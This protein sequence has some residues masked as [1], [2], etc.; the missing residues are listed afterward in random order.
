MLNWEQEINIVCHILYMNMWKMSNIRFVVHISRFIIHKNIEIVLR[1]LF[2]FSNNHPINLLQENK[3]RDMTAWHQHWKEIKSYCTKLF[4]A[5]YSCETFVLT[6][7]M[8]P[9]VHHQGLNNI[10]NHT[11]P[12]W[13]QK[14]R[15]VQFWQSALLHLW[16]T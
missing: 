2:R 5:I 14:S 11:R 6:K 4:P 9:A 10:K 15:S 13:R 16:V 3:M 7:P 1:F 8:V 12:Q